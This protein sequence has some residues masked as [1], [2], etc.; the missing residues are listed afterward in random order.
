MTA[1]LMLKVHFW[2]LSKIEILRKSK[3]YWLN[4]IW[5][6]IMGPRYHIWCWGPNSII[7]ADF[8]QNCCFLATNVD[9]PLF[10][11]FMHVKFILSMGK[12]HLLPKKQQFC[13]KTATV[14]LCWF[15]YHWYFQGRP[16]YRFSESPIFTCIFNMIFQNFPKFGGFDF[17]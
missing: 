10:Y 2:K 13:W 16:K 5:I 15:A 1:Y 12:H 11:E 6:I 14:M 8:Q 7:V 17:C 3:T 9:F 4:L